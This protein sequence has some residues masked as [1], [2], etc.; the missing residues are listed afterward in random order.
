MR[1]S[2]STRCEVTSVWLID[3]DS[4]VPSFL[5]SASTPSSLSAGM[6][7]T[8]S[9][10]GEDDPERSDRES[11]RPP[12]SLTWGMSRSATWLGSATIICIDPLVT[13][14]RLKVL[15]C[16]LRGGGA[17]ACGTETVPW[18]T[19]ALLAFGMLASSDAGSLPATTPSLIG[20]DGAPSRLSDQAQPPPTR[21]AM[22]TAT[23]ITLRNLTVRADCVFSGRRRLRRHRGP[24]HARGARGRRR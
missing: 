6:R 8:R 14:S 17:G 16:G 2:R 15:S 9:M 18:G 12:A 1:A 19:P 3:I 21:D 7:T 20:E 10:V 11:T 22:T 4:T 23:A 5:A 13:M 24:H